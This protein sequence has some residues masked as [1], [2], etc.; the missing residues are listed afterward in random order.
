MTGDHAFSVFVDAYRKG[1]R[2]FDAEAAYRLMRRNATETPPED[3]YKDGRGRRALASYLKYGYVPL[4]DHVE[5]AFHKDEQVSRTLDYSYDDALLAEFAAELGHADDAALF[6]KRAGYWRNVIDPG[7]GFARGR[8][9]DGSWVTPTD[10]IAPQTWVTEGVPIQ[11]TFSVPQDMPG[12]VGYLGG[13]KEFETK[14]DQLFAAK[15]YDATNEPSN[16]LGYLYDF[17]AAPWKTQQ[18]LRE[19]MDTKYS[20][21]P[22]GIPGNDDSGQM[23]AWYVFSAMGFYPVS[24]GLPEYQIG[25]PRFDDMTVR[26]PSGKAIHIVASGAEAGARYVRAVAWNGQPVTP[27]SRGWTIAHADLIQ[28][29]ELVFTMSSTPGAMPPAASQ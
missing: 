8:H 4:E 9:A 14:L 18:H 12:L 13:Q 2:N 27:S 29:G 28:G 5:T 6:G 15:S 7:T 22:A 23:S 10:P 3:Q 25:T 21:Q 20:D 16:S 1:I 26:L 17:T 19:L 11:Y 24:P